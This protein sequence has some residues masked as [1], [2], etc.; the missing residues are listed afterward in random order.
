VSQE[1]P[2]VYVYGVAAASELAAISIRGVNG[3]T[4]RTTEHAGLAAL[5]SDLQ[6]NALAAAKE[7]RAHWQ[8]LE[9]A[10][11]STT[12]L[13]TRFGTV[14][15]SEDAVR[16]RLLAANM[17]RLEELLHGVAG[18]VQLNVKGDY[19][20]L[21]LMREVVK[22]SPTIAAL[23]DKLR[24]L[25]EAAGYY[26]RIRMG[27]LVAAEIQRLAAADTQ[28]AVDTLAPRAA[29]VREEEAAQPK[30]AFNLALLVPRDGESA[31]TE[32]V[33]E[34]AAALGDRVVIRYVGPLPPY[35][36]ADANLSAEAEAWA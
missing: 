12:V 31:F 29:D 9:E 6:D 23:R 8:V 22:A 21:E 34:L 32:A 33:N 14:M 28:L 3:A 27:E 35:S 18:H 16:E 15:E 25:P 20:Q 10:C 5:T 36:F 17:E 26:E 24:S 11:Q 30:T 7:V 2:T 13:P 1:A 19:D 4:V